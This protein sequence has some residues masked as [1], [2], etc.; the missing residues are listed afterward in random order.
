MTKN[1][2]ALLTL[3][4]SAATFSATAAIPVTQSQVDARFFQKQKK[5]SAKAPAG[6]QDTWFEG[7][8]GRPDSPAMSAQDWLP[9]GWQD[10]SRKGNT[11]PTDRT[12]WNLTWQVTSNDY[13]T[14]HNPSTLAVAYQGNAFAYIMADVAYDGH[15]EL[16]E[17]DEWLITPTTT[18]TG[19]DWLYF[20]LMYNAG[21]T[22]YN[23]DTNTFDGLNNNLQVYASTDDGENWTLIW[24]LA[25]NEIKTKFSEEEL[26]ADLSKYET[27]YR[28]VYVSIKDYLG[29]PTKFAFRYYGR[30]GQPMA[31]DNVA[32]GVPQPKANYSIPNG[33][34]Y[35]GVTPN[36]DYP[37]DPKMMIPFGVEGTWTNKSTDVLRSEWQYA[38]A[39]GA[40]AVWNEDNLTTPAYSRLQTVQAPVLTGYFESR[41]SEPYT[42]S[43][44]KMQAGGLLY[45]S[46]GEGYSGETS[47]G[48]YDIFSC[49]P[50]QTPKADGN[51]IF[52]LNAKIDDAWE[53]R[54]GKEPGMLDILG[55]GLYCP[56]TAIPF[57]FDYVQMIAYIT[58]T[59]PDDARLEVRVVSL[60]ENGEPE[61]LLGVS[62]L[63]GKDLPE[64]DDNTPIAL[65]FQFP[66]PVYADRDIMIVISGLRESEG[67]LKFLYLY[68]MDPDVVA[69]SYVI[70]SEW[71]AITQTQA[72]YFG[73]LQTLL[74]PKGYF[75]G[76]IMN[77]GASYSWMELEGDN[78][79]TIP[80]EGGSKEF[81]IK[82]CHNPERWRLT[83]DN[84]T[85]CDW[86]SFD[87]TYDEA[88]ET[89]T[90]KVTAQPNNTAAVRK[91]DLFISSP[92]SR[93]ALSVHQQAGIE[94]VVDSNRPAVSFNGQEIIVSGGKASAEVFDIAG[95]RMASAT[96]D[97]N[98]TAIDATSFPKGV[99]AV[100]V[101]GKIS[102][103][104]IK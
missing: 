6:Q 90:V 30:A 56:K 11:P 22:L 68:S 97:G 37:L 95:R 45:G 83:T 60:N 94:S 100:K 20:K 32:V 24:D 36:F 48:I 3:A 74:I 75:A 96:L 82:A 2:Y 65:R 12:R 44:S 19:D 59:I 71:D 40:Q 28:P 58:E 50:I 98:T 18:A 31:M 66:T 42:L 91:G 39:S 4:L 9:E 87:A 10:V 92:G 70:M 67:A 35:E 53:L 69:N 101:D 43:H 103:K 77:M 29:K 17:Q 78:T 102:A 47:V 57:G 104:I 1:C 49:T 80:Q 79:F 23:R 55:F 46:D 25:E 99:Y 63:F 41:A 54:L 61:N 26:R 73:N 52:S 38:D 27:E 89:Y 72:E 34:F 93:V 88:T 33:F 15:Y 7:F 86:A 8:E 14:M 81:K 62:E 5:V 16:D 21:W 64:A 85:V 84:V 13:I 51:G 76:L